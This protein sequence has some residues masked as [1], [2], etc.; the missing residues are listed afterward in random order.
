MTLWRLISPFPPQNSN[1]HYIRGEQLP[2]VGCGGVAA[3]V[4][5]AFISNLDMLTDL[6]GWP[7]VK[8]LFTAVGGPL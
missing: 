2:G 7:W 8:F 3:R 4:T 5:N 6:P 1:S